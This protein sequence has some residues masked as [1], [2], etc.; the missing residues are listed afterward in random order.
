M[1]YIKLKDHLKL[2][3]WY[4]NKPI[5]VLKINNFGE[6]QYCIID[7]KWASFKTKVWEQDFYIDAEC[8]EMER[9]KKLERIINA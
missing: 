6:R 8:I 4:S 9:M 1:K 2:Y 7:F 3:P 5:F